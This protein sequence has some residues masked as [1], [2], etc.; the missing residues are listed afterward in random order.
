MIRKNK[1]ALKYRR[2]MGIRHF[3]SLNADNNHSRGRLIDSKKS[4]EGKDDATVKETHV[5]VD[6]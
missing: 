6:S 5:T 3:R 1:R 2:R 4:E